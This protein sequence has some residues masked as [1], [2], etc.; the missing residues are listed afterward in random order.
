MIF[1]A[2]ATRVLITLCHGCYDYTQRDA[3]RRVSGARYRWRAGAALP[4]FC[5][6]CCYTMSDI[7]K[8]A[9]DNY[10]RPRR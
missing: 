6:R 1:F 7:A 3:A 10:A 2:G 4:L 8:R 9:I 5:F